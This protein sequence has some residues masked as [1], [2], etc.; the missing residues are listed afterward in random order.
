M[1]ISRAQ[2]WVS[3]STAVTLCTLNGNVLI[4]FVGYS[5]FELADVQSIAPCRLSAGAR[6][7]G[8]VKQERKSVRPKEGRQAEARD[9][10]RDTGEAGSRWSA[11]EHDNRYI[12]VY[13]GAWSGRA[14]AILRSSPTQTLKKDIHTNSATRVNTKTLG[15]VAGPAWQP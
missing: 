10:E 4:F 2:L 14:N 15:Y 5:A 9:R 11:R 3:N 8:I 1:L 7:T 6:P 12:C 13:T